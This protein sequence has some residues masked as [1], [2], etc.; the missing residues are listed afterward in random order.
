LVTAALWA[1]STP[2]QHA[3]PA[4]P[5]AIASQPQSNANSTFAGEIS[6]MVKSGSTPLPGVEISAANTLTGQKVLTST[7]AA[8]HFSLNVAARGRYVVRAQ[9]PA[10]AAVTKEAVINPDNP[11]ASIDLEMQ[12]QSRAQAAAARQQQAQQSQ[13]QQ[14][15]QAA[16]AMAGRGFQNLG[17]QQGEAASLAA[18]QGAGNSG[19]ADTGAEAGAAL[20]Q[21]GAENGATESVAVSGRMGNSENFGP[22][23]DD[24]MDRVQEAVRNG[25]GTLNLNGKE[26]Q[27]G[28]P[29]GMG[30]PGGGMGGFGGGSPMMIV[31]GGPGGGGGFGGFGGFG[32]FN[33]NK[34]HGTLFYSVGDP[35]LDATPY[36]LTGIPITKPD[37][38]QNRFGATI[39]GPLNIPHI[40]SGGDKTFYVVNYS[41][42]RNSN[43]FDN[44][45]TVP[46]SAERAGDFSQTLV[47]G[48]PVT[49]YDPLTHQP[50]TNN[51]IPAGRIDAAAQALL[52]F[53]PQPNAPGSSQN[54]H[55][56]T[57]SDQSNDAINIRVI[58][59]FGE[60][61]PRQRGQRA[62]G[63]GGP[64]GRGGGGRRG[65]QPRNNLNVGFNF[66]R[67]N[68]DALTPFP[69]IAGRTSGYGLNVPINYVRSFGRFVT[70]SRVQFNRSR[71]QASSPF[72]GVRNLA[73]QL[74][75]TGVSQSPIDWGVPSI[76]LTHYTGLRDVTPALRRD[77]TWTFGEAL[78][79]SKGKNNWRFGGDF[80]RIQLN[81]RTSQNARGQ[82]TFTG[83]ST[84]ASAVAQGTGYDL[85]DFLLGLPQQTAAQYGVNNYYFRGNSWD[86]YVQNDWRVRGNLTLNLGL[87]YE[88]V[89][90]FTEKYNHLVN[91]DANPA[92]TAVQPVQPG[93][94]GQF[95]GT[96]P[97]TLVNPDRNNFAPRIGIAWRATG[98]TVVRSGYGINYNTGAYSNIVTQ[99]AYQ[100]PF[101][102][103]ETNI[104]SPS[105]PLT[106]ENGFPAVV[107]GTVTNNFGVDRN[108]RLGYVQVANLGI[109]QQVTKTL[110]MNVD[111]NWNKGTR[112]DIERAP[113]RN[114]N[115]GLRIS[116]VQ[117]FLWWDSL[118]D[119]TTNSLSVNVRKRM[120]HG[121]QFG[122]NYVWSKS[123]DDASTIGGGATVVAQ[124]DQDLHAERGASSFD[125]RHR[126]RGYWTYEMPWGTNKRWLASGGA[127]AKVFGDWTLS[128][129]ASLQTGSPFTARVVG[130]FAD[131]A[132]GTN[133]TLRANYNG[134]PIQLNDWTVGQFFNTS[135]FTIPTPGQF[136]NSRR[137][138]IY[139]PGLV[140]FDM[141]ISKNIPIRD[142]QGLNIQ[143]SANNF[144]NHPHFTSI[145]TNLNSPTYG[146]IVGVGAMRK[147]SLS[148][149]Y[150]F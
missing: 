144:L 4:L 114:P 27:I 56:S 23:L 136:G 134:G 85:A 10:F 141:S 53:F 118:G 117:P 48:H 102:F 64:G 91:L 41:G 25:G 62:G 9:F 49:I 8:G 40:Y 100:P 7:D 50:F 80:R 58:H 72:S 128:G 96:V 35:V 149:R 17:V 28:G 44:F 121:I 109:Q 18:E 46:T 150:H 122:A 59:N 131:V 143:L 146:Q 139:G 55:R 132:R 129:V 51:Q 145:D 137:N 69:A 89:S 98:K 125:I 103:T 81:P 26:I 113:N 115:G 30:A 124:N 112:L 47:N 45:Y 60:T 52:T 73:S 142:V 127:L 42:G 16:T 108:Y 90:P 43:P 71:N 104:A 15:Q 63:R 138:M 33:V 1:Q 148:A 92:F 83:F 140:D 119:S 5:P 39:G 29:G 94:T 99:L 107:P 66:Q 87:R 111:Y 84:A 65:L 24:I 97:Q 57:T 37:Y 70:N 106:L 75:I 74:G 116:G 36:S 135:A 11:N 32:R 31:M 6:G 95:T 3:T 76:S 130:S 77:Q 38:M 20:P 61:Q 82:F 126:F 19:N 21:P 110:L 120:Q 67:N 147:I 13:M 79:Y 22:N 88:Y 68:A 93:Q 78:S 2:S 101:T 34:P 105:T 14:I 123:L 54:F 12:L 133:G 86:A